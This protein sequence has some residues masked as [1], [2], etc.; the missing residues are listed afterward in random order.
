MQAF[1][2]DFETCL[3][4]AGRKNYSFSIFGILKVNFDGIVLLT[5]VVLWIKR[6]LIIMLEVA[7]SFEGLI[8]RKKVG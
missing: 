7:K 3:C 8:Q 6:L 4:C 5:N 2:I 1:E